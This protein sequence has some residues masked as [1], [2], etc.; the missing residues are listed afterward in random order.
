MCVKE[1]KTGGK[2]IIE[3]VE[4]DEFK[5]SAIQ[6]NKQCTREVR[7]KVQAVSRGCRRGL[8]CDRKIAENED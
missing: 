8:I 4:V 3:G 2:V 5:G 1:K 7:K 6:I